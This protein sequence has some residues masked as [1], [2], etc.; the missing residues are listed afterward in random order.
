MSLNVDDATT[1]DEIE[2][3]EITDKILEKTVWTR[4]EKFYK[5]QV[6]VFYYQSKSNKLEKDNEVE[7]IWKLIQDKYP[8]KKYSEYAR[9]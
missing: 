2:E 1:K 6:E 3:F 4:E 7:K 9:L 5:K 8:D